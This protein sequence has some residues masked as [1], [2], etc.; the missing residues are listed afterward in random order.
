MA[1]A[2]VTFFFR[3][4]TA[5]GWSESHYA[6]PVSSTVAMQRATQLYQY[7][8]DLL[9]ENG[10]LTNIRASQIGQRS[11]TFNYAV[12]Y[13]S[14][15]TTVFPTVKSDIANSAIMLRLFTLS[16]AQGLDFLRGFPLGQLNSSGQY[17]PSSL[18]SS[19][20]AAYFN[21]LDGGN[22]Y[23]RSLTPNTAFP[24]GPLTV[25]IASIVQTL[26]LQQAAITTTTN[27]NLPVN[28]PFGYVNITGL[29][30][31]PQIRGYRKVLSVL[32]ATSFIIQCSVQQPAYLGGGMVQPVVWQYVPINNVQ[33]S[34]VTHRNA[35]R[36]FGVPRGRRLVR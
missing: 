35:G 21:A 31:F 6:G 1:Q 8:R 5:R 10:Q 14:Q 20:L 29:K 30:S 26:A 3:D 34:G 13:A 11:E 2:K 7:R 28:P 25:G 27:H 36:P 24:P 16:G 17:S 4:V 9:G 15:F 12:P 33:V 18:F 32:T 23:V 22:W 19:T